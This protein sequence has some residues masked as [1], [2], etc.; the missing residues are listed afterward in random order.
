MRA[1][2]RRVDLFLAP[3]Q[4]TV[5]TRPVCIK[6]VVGS[7]VAVC[8]WDAAVRV[9][10]L[11]HY[12]LARPAAHEVP[13]SRYGN[14]ATPL[15]LDRMCRAGADPATMEAAV[16]G[17]GHPIENLKDTRIGE[18]NTAV[19]LEILAARGVRVVRQDTGGRY[20]RKLLFDTGTGKLLV[21]SL[22]DGSKTGHSAVQMAA[23]PGPRGNVPAPPS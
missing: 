10:G 4:L 2:R 9:G 18:A 5:Q 16:V 6:T 23:W 11:N 20:G 21:R 3:G 15:L 12:L 19:A 8:L 22:R 14:F 17:G 13:D 7:C 1:A